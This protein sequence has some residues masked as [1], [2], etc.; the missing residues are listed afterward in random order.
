MGSQFSRKTVVAAGRTLDG[1]TQGSVDAFLLDHGLENAGLVGAVQTRA[2]RLI[3]YLLQNGEA[4]DANGQNVVDT[5][6]RDLIDRAI[7]ARRRHDDFTERF[8]KLARA[9]AADGFA[10][11]GGQLKRAMPVALGLPATD[12]EVHELLKR[13]GFATP[14]G[15]LDQAIQNHG[16]GMWAAANSQL[17]SFMEALLDEIAERITTDPSALPP[18]GHPRRTWLASTA[19][20]P[21]LLGPLNEWD[22]QGRGYV[23]GLFKRLHPQGSHPGLSDEDDSTFRLHTAFVA[24]RLLLRRLADRLVV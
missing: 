4:I 22:G 5:I 16:N 21:F 15:H 7:S 8:P 19:N 6:V 24:A 14:M 1:F 2:N 9:L 17:R 23:E 20:P 13:F 3:D 10:V 11:K 12:D 18:S